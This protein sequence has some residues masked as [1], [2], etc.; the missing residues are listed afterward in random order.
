MGNYFFRGSWINELIYFS[1]HIMCTNSSVDR[2]LSSHVL[3]G[4][5][6][7]T[8]SIFSDHLYRHLTEVNGRDTR[9][10]YMNGILGFQEQLLISSFALKISLVSACG[11]DKRWCQYNQLK[12]T[13]KHSL[14]DKVKVLKILR[15]IRLNWI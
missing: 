2:D 11:A 6:I 7:K 13:S 9:K 10:G 3:V 15:Q 4:D 12:T 1:S 14:H 8:L 5:S